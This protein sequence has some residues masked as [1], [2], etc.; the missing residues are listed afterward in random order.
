[1]KYWRRGGDSNSRYANKTHNGFRD[2]RIQPLCH[3]SGRLLLKASRS[4]EAAASY[5]WCSARGSFVRTI[6]QRSGAAPDSLI[7][8]CSARAQLRGKRCE[9]CKVASAVFLD[10]RT[11]ETTDPR[12]VPLRSVR[13]VKNQSLRLDSRGPVKD[14]IVICDRNRPILQEACPLLARPVIARA[15]QKNR[16]VP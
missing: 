5:P 6:I 3:P 7:R 11:E 4:C 13:I 8:P 2:H 16:V 1:M 15:H 14:V 10:D 9:R 12:P